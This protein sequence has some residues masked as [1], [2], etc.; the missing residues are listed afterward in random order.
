MVF[1]VNNVSQWK[2]LIVIEN[3]LNKEKNLELKIL[4]R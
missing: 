4:E 1:L 2:D 3:I